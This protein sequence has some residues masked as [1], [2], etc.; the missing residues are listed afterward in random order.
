MSDHDLSGF[1]SASAERLRS[2]EPDA[3]LEGVIALE[4]VAREHPREQPAIMAVLIAFVRE[5]AYEAPAVPSRPLRPRRRVGVGP[6]LQAA[7]T[8]LA[9]RDAGLD[10]HLVDLS[11]AVL[12]HAV[13]SGAFLAKALLRGV[14]LTGARLD[15]ADLRGT[16]I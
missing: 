6:D 3:R 5:R 10:T 2:A 11:G 1:R 12:P 8:A 15:G 7:L 13:L 4:R 16:R 9:R 14:D